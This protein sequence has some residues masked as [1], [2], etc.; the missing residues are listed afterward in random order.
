[1]WARIRIGFLPPA[2][3]PFHRA[4]IDTVLSPGAAFVRQDLDVGIG[5]AAL[6]QFG[7]DER[8]HLRHLSALGDGRD[9]DRGL[10]HRLGPRLPRG[11]EFRRLR[12]RVGGQRGGGQAGE[13]NGSKMNA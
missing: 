3:L 2:P 7:G 1:M 8:G 5:P 10:E 13:Q 9:F 12:D 6:L 4:T 11:I